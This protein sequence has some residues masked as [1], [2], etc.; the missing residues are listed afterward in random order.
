MR[1]LIPLGGGLFCV[2]AASFGLVHRSLWEAFVT[3]GLVGLGVG[4]TFAALP[5]LIIRSVPHQETGSATGLYQLLRNVGLSTGS[6]LSTAT[7]RFTTP[8]GHLLPDLGGFQI[9]MLVAA[10]MCIAAAALSWI[11]PGATLGT[12]AH[13]GH[14]DAAWTEAQTAAVM[15]EEG[16]LEATGAMFVDDADLESELD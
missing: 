2:G 8:T 1:A 15:A 7:L 13:S 4:F 16:A 9:A 3:M 12:S 10:G 11:L 5:G 14:T 6:A